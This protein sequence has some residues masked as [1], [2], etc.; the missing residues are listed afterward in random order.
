MIDVRLTWQSL[1]NILMRWMEVPSAYRDG[2]DPEKLPKWNKMTY[3]SRALGAWAGD[4][5]R[6]TAGCWLVFKSWHGGD[7]EGKTRND[8]GGTHEHG[9]ELGEGAKGRVM[10]G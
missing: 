6:S 4:T 9:D 10:Q 3:H 8:D 5:G 2:F 7:D 1:F